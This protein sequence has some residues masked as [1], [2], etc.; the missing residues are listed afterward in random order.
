MSFAPGLPHS[1]IE[2]IEGTVRAASSISIAASIFVIGSYLGSDLFQTPINR[3][4]FYATWGNI[5]ANVGTMIAR[6]GIEDSSSLC[7]FQAF[8]LQWFFG[9][10]AFWIFCMAFNVYMTLFHQ[11]TS[12]DL[13]KLEWRYF[14]FCYGVP[15]VPA[16][17]F[18]ILTSEG[19]AKI[20]GSSTVRYM[21]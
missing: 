19:T 8:F 7:L 15:F 4:I 11:Y 6:G 20:Y 9:S 18:L 2:A 5:L 12:R 3:L 1:Q 17:V 13:K 21:T 16:L 14:L 10:D